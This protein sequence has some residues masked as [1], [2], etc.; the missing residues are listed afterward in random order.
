MKIGTEME[1]LPQQGVF[2][3]MKTL[4]KQKMEPR[5]A[6]KEPRDPKMTSRSTLGWQK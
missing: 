5:D 1:Q 3:E 6:H 2:L 4:G